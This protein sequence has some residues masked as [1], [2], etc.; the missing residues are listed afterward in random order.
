[1]AV[2]LRA[3]GIIVALCLAW[4]GVAKAQGTPISEPIAESDTYWGGNYVDELPSCDGEVLCLALL[5]YANR[6]DEYYHGVIQNNTEDWVRVRD[7]TV[8]LFDSSGEF[9]AQGDT[10]EVAPGVISPGGHALI[11]LT[12]SGEYLSED[13]TTEAQFDFEPSTGGADGFSVP[14][15][16]DSAEIRGSAILGEMTSTSEYIFNYLYVNAACF[17]ED[18][19][20][21]Y[22]GGGDA[23]NGPY[24]SGSTDR[25]AVELYGNECTNFVV[26]AY[27]NPF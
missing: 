8:T 6:G 18:G 25:F 12:V 10:F 9:A 14:V 23:R 13:F 26:N 24:Q 2:S 3:I 27:G 1:M 21:S 22:T 16:V 15:R 7:V 4:P 19:S 11:G 17:D 5:S 20:I